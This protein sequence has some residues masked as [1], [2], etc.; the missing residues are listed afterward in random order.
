VEDRSNYKYKALS[1]THTHTHT[2]RE[3]ERERKREKERERER[4]NMFP[5]VL[6]ETKGGGNEKRMKRRV[7]KT[8]SGHIC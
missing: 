6:E 7:N 2:E 5:R 1:H 4:E 8:E 3:R